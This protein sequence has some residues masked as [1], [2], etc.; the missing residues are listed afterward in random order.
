MEFNPPPPP[1]PSPSPPPPPSPSSSPPPPY[2]RTSSPSTPSIIQTQATSAELTSL[3]LLRAQ[4]REFHNPIH[5][6]TQ[7][8]TQQTERITL[9]EHKNQQLQTQM[10]MFWTEFDRRHDEGV[11]ERAVQGCLESWNEFLRLLKGV[12]VVGVLGLVYSF[13]CLLLKIGGVEGI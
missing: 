13:L 11:R 7:Q 1:P 6:H 12:L 4:A 5:S 8:L 3:L 9:L 10:Q 2:T